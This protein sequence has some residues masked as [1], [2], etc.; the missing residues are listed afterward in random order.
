MPYD[1]FISFNY[2]GDEVRVNGELAIDALS[3]DKLI[4]NLLKGKADNPKVNAIMLL[5]GEIYDT[6]YAFHEAY[7]RQ[8]DDA[9]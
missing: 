8:V 1:L 2:D 4:V 3:E 9:R 7:L 5:E 6:H